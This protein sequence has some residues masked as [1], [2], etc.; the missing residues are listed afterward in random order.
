[1]SWFVYILK[2]ADNTLY[3]GISTDCERRLA[4]HNLGKGAKYTRNRLPA[5]LVYSE[6]AENRSV[7]SK[8]EY[9]IKQLTRKQKITLFKL[10]V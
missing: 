4:Q 1:M 2:C 10:K 3:T 6:P 9:E 5:V 7:A 8:R